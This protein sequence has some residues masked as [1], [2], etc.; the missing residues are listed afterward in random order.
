MERGVYTYEYVNAPFDDITLMLAEHADR[1]LQP[2]TE[3]AASQAEE[4][5]R[6]LSATVA[7]IEVSQQAKISVE[8]FVPTGPRSG[9]LPLRWRAARADAL[10]P[11]MEAALEVAA[12]SLHPPITQISLIGRYR[13]PF[14]VIGW[15]ADA[16][17]GHRVA[18]MAASRFVRGVAATL[19]RELSNTLLASSSP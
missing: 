12:V 2:A 18:E 5:V 13:P 7:G 1:V 16:L 3:D 11:A 8:R 15:A 6:S 4:L 9:V 14:G 17:I 10:F 19:E